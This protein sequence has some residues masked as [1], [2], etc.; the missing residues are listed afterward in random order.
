MLTKRLLALPLV[1]A[2][3][4]SV[5]ACNN[6][7]G[8]STPTGTTDATTVATTALDY[9]CPIL[10]ALS[11]SSL[12]MTDAQRAVLNTSV[13]SCNTYTVGGLSAL[14]NPAAVA[15]TVVEALALYQSLTAAPVATAQKQHTQAL[16]YKLH[17]V[18]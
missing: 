18:K 13:L 4:W 14:T 3:C 11:L 8:G 16:L 2:I 7:S 12:K 17:H 10:S 6:T 9:A 15:I 1:A 5:A